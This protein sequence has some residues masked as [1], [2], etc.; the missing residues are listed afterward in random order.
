MVRIYAL[1]FVIA[2]LGSIG[3]GAKYYYDTTQA[4]IATLRENNVK[5]ESAVET[6]EQS[7]ATLQQDMVKIGQLN[8]TLTISLQKAEAYGDELRTK[9][10]KLNLVVEALRDS[11]QLEGKMN[12]ATAK[13][14]RGFMEDTGNNDGSQSPLPDWLRGK[15]SGD[16]DQN[17]SQDR[18][19]NSSSSSKT[20]TTLTD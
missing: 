16:G 13:L 20:E 15:D 19:D 4:T 17:S 10:S 2:I 3:Y 8:K 18:E 1:I 11:K 5:L 12:G 7:V 9:L 6:A 14:W